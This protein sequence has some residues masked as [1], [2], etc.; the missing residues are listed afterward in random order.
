MFVTS[1]KN[2]YELIQ[3]AIEKNEAYLGVPQVARYISRE[4]VDLAYKLPAFS[5]FTREDFEKIVVRGCYPIS[6]QFIW[7][8]DNINY[9]KTL[10]HL[11]LI[12]I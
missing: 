9:R 10:K 5:G 2:N 11:L 4:A 6:R 8:I 7:L 3:N 12:R 1:S